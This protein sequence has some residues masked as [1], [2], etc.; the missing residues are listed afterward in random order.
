M[1]TVFHT[2]LKGSYWSYSSGQCEAFVTKVP[3][4]SLFASAV[5]E[6]VAWLSVDS[7][8]SLFA[9]KSPSVGSAYGIS[10]GAGAGAGGV[11]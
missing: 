4:F 10:A 2:T 6:L 1:V 7:V 3:F 8:V 5:S 11:G 9:T